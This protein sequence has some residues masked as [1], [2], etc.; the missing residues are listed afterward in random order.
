VPGDLIPSDL[1]TLSQ[2]LSSWFGFQVQLPSL[3]QTLRNVDKAISRVVEAGGENLASRFDRSTAGIN[4]RAASEV[5][6]ISEAERLLLSRIGADEDLT[7]R[8]LNYVFHDTILRQRN[9]ET[10]ARL[11]VEHI[12]D[13]ADNTRDATAEIDDDWLNTFAGFAGEKSNSDVRH[14]WARILSGKIRQ[15]SS[16]SLHSL[17]LLAA[18]DSSDAKAIHNALQYVIN[19]EFVFKHNWADLSLFI[20]MDDLSVISGT[21]GLLNQVVDLSDQPV[22]RPPR[23]VSYCTAHTIFVAHLPRSRFLIPVFPL[24]R[25]GKELSKLAEGVSTD[26]ESANTFGNGAEYK[27]V[28]TTQSQTTLSIL[29]TS[30]RG[31]KSVWAGPAQ[32]LS[33]LTRPCGGGGWQA[34]RLH[35]PTR[36]F[37]W[38]TRRVSALMSYR[39]VVPDDCGDDVFGPGRPGRLW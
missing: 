19:N 26:P 16:F 20:Q 17:T 29:M 38:G 11:A 15:P 6:I 23:P 21:S 5:A 2:R 36:L 34:H 3:P 8:T 13:I 32:P 22:D 39:R 25:F 30:K 27:K 18:V 9:R 14:L 1:P 33:S 31:S 12:A 37:H 35:A 10:I 24:T 7:Q 4:A 28:A